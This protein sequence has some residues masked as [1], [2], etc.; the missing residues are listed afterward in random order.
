MPKPWA[1]RA[2]ALPISP[3]PPISPM[4]LP[5]TI[6][7]SRWR[8][9]PPGNF[10]ARTS[11]SPSIMRRAT[12]IIRPKLRSAVA[13]VVTGGTTVTGMRR[14]VA[15]ATSTFDGEIDCDA[16]WRSFGLAA[17]TARSMRSCSRQNRI[18]AFLTAAI[19]AVFGMILL[20]SG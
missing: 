2:T 12:A 5:H 13:S 16:M 17:M 4:V 19:S 11:R 1:R 6:E 3:P 8:D 7:P 15:S 20:S 10:P 14:A 9:C 18:S